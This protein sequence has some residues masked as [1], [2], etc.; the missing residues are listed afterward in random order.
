MEQIRTMGPGTLLAK[1]DIKSVFRLLPVHPADRHL[2]AMKWKKQLY[3]D[4]CLPF[5]LRS[6]PKL[7]NILADLL[8]CILENMGVSPLLHYLDDFL[9]LGTP[10]TLTC[11]HNLQIIKGVCQ[12]L[13]VPL[14]LE[15]VEG[16]SGSLTFLGILLDTKNMEARLPLQK[17]CR[18][19]SQ[20][21]TWLVR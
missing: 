7:F 16:P 13:G 5:G 11:S 8:S 3:I 6:A 18:I 20:V 9:T 2:L 17:L 19:R 12:H 14:A 21:A 4:T 1:I 15:K 10:G